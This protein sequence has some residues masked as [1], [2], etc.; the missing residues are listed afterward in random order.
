[1]KLPMRP[2]IGKSQNRL[3]ANRKNG[4]VMRKPDGTYCDV[5]TDLF[6]RTGGVVKFTIGDQIM[7]ERLLAECEHNYQQ[8]QESVRRQLDGNMQKKIEEERARII[9]LDA[10]LDAQ[11]TPGAKAQLRL[12]LLQFPKRYSNCIA[13]HF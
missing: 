5:A 10:K 13:K 4:S 8:L 1:M 2:A 11:N 7:D 6:P 9:A 12:E 3:R